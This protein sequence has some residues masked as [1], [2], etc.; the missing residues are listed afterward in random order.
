[1]MLGYYF[2]LALAS[3]KRNVGLTVLMIAAIA[4]GI[5]ASMIVLVVYRAEAGDPIPD[6]AHQLY[7]VQV[8]NWGSERQMASSSARSDDLEDQLSYADAVAL[9]RAHAAKRQAAMYASSM[10]VV[11]ENAHLSPF[12]VSARATYGDFFAMFDVP[13]VYG[14]PWPAAAD[15]DHAKVVVISNK[16]NQS[17]FDGAN[18]VGRYVRFMDGVYRVA[19]VIADWRPVPRFYDLTI[20]AY[21][22]TEQV[23]LPFTTAAD[24]GLVANENTDCNKSIPGGVKNLQSDCVWIQFW[25]ELPTAQDARDYRAFL[26]GYARQQQQS[27]RFHWLARTRLRDVSQWLQY[28]GVVS[29]QVELMV[30]VAF[31]FFLVCLV[32]AAGLMLA[33]VMEQSTRIATRRAI[34]A[35][36]WAILTQYLTEAALVGAA[37]GVAG[38]LVTQLGLS[39]AGMLFSNDI[40]KIV[41]LGPSS[42][43]IEVS[44]AVLAT[45]L[46]ALYPTWR[47]IRVNCA[48][49]LKTR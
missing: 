21:G 15:E 35:D 40:F 13:F 49:Q 1:M 34:G 4:V 7:A 6:K 10:T 45:L 38:L 17:L 12:N 22:D 19:G 39:G 37:G 9:M 20:A 42:A 14:G 26:S 46:A 16:L 47:A 29:G 30:L 2:S 23:F 24:D 33:K 43:S 5:G 25:V 3:L 28:E 18:S 27:G 44:L 41:R 48:S 36:R 11:P 31:G 8:D 32:N